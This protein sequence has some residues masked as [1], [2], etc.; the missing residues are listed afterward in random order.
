MLKSESIAIKLRQDRLWAFSTLSL[1]TPKEEEASLFTNRLQ[2]C[3]TR[4]DTPSHPV[5]VSRCPEFGLRFLSSWYH[6]SIL[7]AETETRAVDF[8]MDVESSTFH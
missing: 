5:A 1:E 3:V 7:L 6:W 2:S 8:V 4:N